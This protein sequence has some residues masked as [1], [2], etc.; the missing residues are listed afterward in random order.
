MLDK[1]QFLN[2][3]KKLNTLF[4]DFDFDLEDRFALNCWYDVFKG[5]SDSDY[6]A[7]IDL[8]VYSS[9]FAPNSPMS[10]IENYQ[11]KMNDKL[12]EKYLNP[13]L[14]WNKMLEIMDRNGGLYYNYNKVVAAMERDYPEIYETFKQYKSDLQN[15]VYDDQYFIA[16]WKKT[17]ENIIKSKIN[18]QTVMQL[19]LISQNNKLLQIEEGDKNDNRY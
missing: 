16:Q 1:I 7:M 5:F 15:E 9:K 14:A 10:L 3:I 13:N 17:Y 11:N 12:Y 19:G 4:R 2:G 6:Q 18:K 8:Y